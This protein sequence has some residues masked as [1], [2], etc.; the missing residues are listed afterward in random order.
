MTIRA[1]HRVRWLAGWLLV[2]PGL[3]LASDA[4]HD[5][6]SGIECISCHVGHHAPGMNLTS[7]ESPSI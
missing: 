1:P 6:A 7:M 4:P 3:S 2:V 5:V